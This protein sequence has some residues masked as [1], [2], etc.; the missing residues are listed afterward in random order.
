M[1]TSIGR[2]SLGR[3][4]VAGNGQAA[5][6]ILTA[7]AGSGGCE[8]LLGVAPPGEGMRHGWQPALAPTAQQLGVRLLQPVAV[9]SGDV[10]A[11]I[12]AFRPTLLLSVCY[13]Q[14]FDDRLL[15]EVDG[16]ALNF[17]PSLL[18]R[19]RGVAPLIWA[20]AEGDTRTGVTVHH[21]DTGIDTGD[22]V[23]QRSLAIHP[24]DTGYRLHQK[25]SRLMVGIGLDLL[26]RLAAGEALPVGEPQSGSSS[27]HRRS[28][29]QL[30][31]VDWDDGAER[32]RNVVRALA[33][34]LPG[35]FFTHRSG[36][37]VLAKVRSELRP[38]RARQAMVGSVELYDDGTPAVQAADGS[39]VVERLVLD[40]TTV[41]GADGFAALGIRQGD[42]LP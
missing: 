6:E 18:P 41:S 32:I 35:A 37:V 10:F 33:P 39:V 40:G 30:N 19:H 4:I 36:Q 11:E 17:H 26:R 23:V 42:V 28:D 15:G 16:P 25:T 12:A 20:I 24:L 13:T 8:D 3:V 1:T 34:P 29:P 5:G 9:R 31:H 21:L 7:R 22:V 2:G 38:R 14:I 27:E